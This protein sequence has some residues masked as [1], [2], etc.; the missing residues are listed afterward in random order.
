MYISVDQP[1]RSIRSTADGWL[2]LGGEGHKVGQDDDTRRR[3]AA[4]EA[5]AAEEFGPARVEHRWSAQDYRV[6]RPPALRGPA[7]GPRRRVRGHRLR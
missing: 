2:V 5:W 1:S 4:L 6:R 7:A 3:Y